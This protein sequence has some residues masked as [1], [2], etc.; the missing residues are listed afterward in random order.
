MRIFESTVQRK[1]FGP[2]REEETGDCSR[3]LN[4]ERY[5]LHFSYSINIGD[6]TKEGEMYGTCGVHASEVDA[7]FWWEKPEGVGVGG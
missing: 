4:E 7:G 2:K 5:N 6:Q 1:I 3:L